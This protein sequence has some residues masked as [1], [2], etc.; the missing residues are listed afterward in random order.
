VDVRASDLDITSGASPA[1]IEIVISLKAAAVSGVAQNPNT[2]S[3]TPGAI[4]VLIPQD[5]QRKD[6]PTYYKFV[7]SD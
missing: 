6:Q 1:D 4:V 2:G 5:Q 3:P 7:P